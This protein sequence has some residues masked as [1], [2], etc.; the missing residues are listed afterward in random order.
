[1]IELELKAVVPDVDDLVDRLRRSGASETF[2]GRMT[3]VR[4]DYPGTP[5][6]LRDEVIRLRVYQ[7]TRGTTSASLDWKG[8]ASIEA[9]YK[10]R[11]ELNVDVADPDTFRAVLLRIGLEATRTIDREVHQFALGDA[12][13]RIE[14]YR[15][16]DDLVEVE[17]EPSGIERAIATMGI[18][19]SA[20]SADNLATFAERFTARTGLPA[21][22]GAGAETVDAHG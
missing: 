16:M 15:Q 7:D 3:D 2:W 4:Y 19:R 13:I 11:E 10:R 21:V 18:Q 14:R 5:L 8:P 1:V 12:M 22:T 9:G 20:F 17:G 6:T